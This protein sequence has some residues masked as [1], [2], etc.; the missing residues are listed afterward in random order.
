MIKTDTQ[1]R[2]VSLEKTY[3]FSHC[4]VEGSA[5]KGLVFNDTVIVHW[6]GDSEGPL[7]S[8]VEKNSWRHRKRVSCCQFKKN[9]LILLLLIILIWQF[10]W[11]KFL[12]SPFMS[13]ILPFDLIQPT[14]D[15][16]NVHP[17]CISFTAFGQVWQFDIQ[18]QTCSVVNKTPISPFV[19]SISPTGEWLIFVRNYNL[20]LRDLCSGVEKSLTVDGKI[21]F[22]YGAANTSWGIPLPHNLDVLWSSDAKPYISYS[23]GYPFR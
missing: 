13:L 14:L 18:E 1:R 10:H 21:D 11:L 17:L 3:Q 2:D 20:W 16:D 6:I 12:G 23:A 22:S 5:K 8:T 15:A 9:R 7:V 4:L 19:E